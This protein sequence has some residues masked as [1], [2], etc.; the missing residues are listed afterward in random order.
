MAGDGRGRKKGGLPARAGKASS[1][2]K[3]ARHFNRANRKKDKRVQRSSHGKWRTT[4]E[5][6]TH[7]RNVRTSKPCTPL[8]PCRTPK[9][10]A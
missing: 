8:C 3:R 6:N 4:L 7:E 9:E 10:P 2:V 5:L 1:V